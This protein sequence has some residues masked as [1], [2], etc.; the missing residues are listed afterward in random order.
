MKEKILKIPL[1]LVALS[2]KF[3]MQ[4]A[5]LNFYQN[6]KKFIPNLSIYLFIYLFLHVN[7]FYYSVHNYS[8]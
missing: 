2:F 6:Q 4:L 3:V 5:F 7:I 8:L 1:L